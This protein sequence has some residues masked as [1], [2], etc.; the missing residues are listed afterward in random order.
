MA[1]SPLPLPA[2]EVPNSAP[3][4]RWS[5]CSKDQTQSA[6]PLAAANTSTQR[7]LPN[8]QET[9]QFQTSAKTT[10][11]QTLSP[12]KE[13]PPKWSDRSGPSRH[14]KAGKSTETRQTMSTTTSLQTLTVISLLPSPTMAMPRLLSAKILSL[15]KEVTD[16]FSRDRIHHALLLDAQPSSR[17]LLPKKAISSNTQSV[18]SLIQTSFTLFRMNPW[19]LIRLDMSGTHQLHEHYFN[20][21]QTYYLRKSTF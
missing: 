11:S 19:L 20:Q 17:K 14:Q 13:S 21:K 9:I 2:W 16:W 5:S 3:D 7:Q 12:T 6:P 1:T 10:T 4:R 15:L 18:T 8:H